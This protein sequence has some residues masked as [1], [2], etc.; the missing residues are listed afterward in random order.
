ML[1][2]SLLVRRAEPH[3]AGVLQ[4]T[5]WQ[6]K[7]P[8]SQTL[9]TKH[10][11]R[12]SGWISPGEHREAMT[13]RGQLASERS[14]SLFQMKGSFREGCGEGQGSSSGLTGSSQNAP[15]HC[16]QTQHGLFARSLLPFSCWIMNWLHVHPPLSPTFHL[17]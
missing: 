17:R 5:E 3:A 7:I 14:S 1:L 13:Q 11:I 16:V 15:S 12:A 10:Q 8:T 2:Q 4:P 9:Q 6:G